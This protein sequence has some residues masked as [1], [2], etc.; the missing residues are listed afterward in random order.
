MV[1]PGLPPRW[2]GRST[3]IYPIRSWCRCKNKSTHVKAT[4]FVFNPPKVRQKSC[5]QI[6]DPLA[7]KLG[8]Y[9]DQTITAQN[10]GKYRPEWGLVHADEA[11]NQN[12]ILILVP[13]AAGAGLALGVAAAPA[14]LAWGQEAWAAYQVATQG[15]SWSAAA[16]SGAF[17]SGAGYTGGAAAGAGWDWFK[18]GTNFDAAFDQRF[19]YLGLGTSMS[20]GAVNGVLTTQMFQWANVPNAFS[21]LRTPEGVVIRL[22]GFATGKS[23]GAAAQGAVQAHENKQ[24]ER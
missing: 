16:G 14:T 18:N 15:Y 8:L 17:S 22:N 10:Y 11:V 20:L 23:V 13:A 24:E 9:V 6:G 4:R 12:G 21:N 1:E 2:M 5:R 7:A 19:S 3:T